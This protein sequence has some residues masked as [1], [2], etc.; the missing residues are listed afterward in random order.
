MTAL[1]YINKMGGKV[2]SLVGVV[3]MILEFALEHRIH[4]RAEYISTL[5][6]KI[7]DRLSRQFDN[8]Q[9]KR[10]CAHTFLEIVARLVDIGGSTRLEI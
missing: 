9:I 2:H 3:K 4:L 6:N 8:P 1:I 5:D 10:K 7:A